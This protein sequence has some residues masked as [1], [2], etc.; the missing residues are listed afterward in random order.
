MMQI[1]LQLANIID[2]RNIN[3]Q[4]TRLKDEYDLKNCYTKGI[5]STI[6]LWCY[7]YPS[8]DYNP[9]VSIF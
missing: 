2:G 3:A 5:M 7:C 1:E 4:A 6:R 8:H 9:Y